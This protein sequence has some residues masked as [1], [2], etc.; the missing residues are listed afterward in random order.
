MLREAE[1]DLFGT[2]SD[3]ES[4]QSLMRFRLKHWK[5]GQ[6][7]NDTWPKHEMRNIQVGQGQVRADVYLG[8]GPIAAASKKLGRPEPRLERLAID[9]LNQD[10]ELSVRFDRRTND[11]QI[12]E[13]RKAL[14]LASW[15]GGVGSRSRNG[16]G[17]LTFQ[18]DSFSRLPQFQ[19]DTAE[20]CQPFTSCFRHDWPHAI[21][22][23]S[24]GPLVW[25]G[26]KNGESFKNWREAVYFLATLRLAIRAAAKKFGRNNDISANQLIA[27][28]V[29]QSKNNVWGDDARIAGSLRLKVVGTERGFVPVAIHL[30]CAVPKF[31]FDK[32][33]IDDQ[34]WVNDNQ[35]KIWAGAHQSIEL[36]MTRLGNKQ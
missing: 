15:F 6:L 36:L 32:L 25:V 26:R 27:Y 9:P 21:G 4:Q 34:Q 12:N 16:W 17:S 13:V 18:D 22:S 23:D 33:N 30:P 10:N 7:N 2:A 31:L 14:R 24:A 3:A 28:P 35:V 1:G 19:V 11:G 5:D 29:T 20:Y 8:F